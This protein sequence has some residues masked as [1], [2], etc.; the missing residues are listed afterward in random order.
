MTLRR[1][2]LL[3][4]P[5]AALLVLAG[6]EAFF[7]ATWHEEIPVR[8]FVPG[9]SF[10]FGLDPAHPEVNAL[11]TRGPEVAVDKGGTFRILVLGDSV[12]FGEG[13]AAAEA[14]PALLESELADLPGGCQVLNAA[15]RGYTAW[16]EAAWFRERGAAL[17]PDLVLVAA[18]LNDVVDPLL[19]WYWDAVP[20]VPDGAIPNPI[21]HRDRAIPVF[22]N[23]RARYEERRAA[24]AAREKTLRSLPLLGRSATWSRCVRLL[25]RVFD[26]PEPLSRETPEQLEGRLT[27]EDTIRIDVLQDP[28]SPEWRWL[29][30]T[31]DGL[32]GDVEGAG[33]RLALVVLPLLYQL[34]NA[35]DPEP[36]AHFRRYAEER[37]IP[38]V[39]F[40]ESFRN[41][42]ED[43]GRS[44][45]RGWVK[46]YYDVW[47]LSPEGHRFAAS[48]LARF[49][50]KEGLLP[51]TLRSG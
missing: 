33:A 9:S 2:K 26:P 6:V 10:V 18:C 25:G 5:L 19:H 44:L 3:A 51:G 39:D 4:I 31:Y 22:K 21:Y 28:D 27:L 40:L 43:A 48:A 29:R 8:V 35:R 15:V 42:G 20:T 17:D 13:V 7:Q 46:G 16:N 37:G 12:A 32:S 1:R 11:G 24:R 36:Q 38:C 41:H 34:E 23:R 49:L 45:F 47:H 50:R 30:S 14:F